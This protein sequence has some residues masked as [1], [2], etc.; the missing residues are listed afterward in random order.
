M[1]KEARILAK[2]QKEDDRYFLQVSK[3]LMRLG[4]ELKY[5]PNFSTPSPKNTTNPDS[6]A[7]NK[8]RGDLIFTNAFQDLLRIAPDLFEELVMDDLV[9]N[10]SV[11]GKG[12]KV[13]L[14]R[15]IPLGR[16]RAR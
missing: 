14:E 4:P 11:R 2:K 10:T 5:G 15:K 3:D 8:K 7:R 9:S 16:Y 1:D 12:K 13:Y 6:L